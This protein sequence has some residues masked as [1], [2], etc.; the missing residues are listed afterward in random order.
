MLLEHTCTLEFFEE[1]ACRD[2]YFRF[3]GSPWILILVFTITAIT[4]LLLLLLGSN[5][6]IWQETI[7]TILQNNFNN[8]RVFVVLV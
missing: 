2:G 5:L 8:L 7:Q 4:F 1:E 6:L 3:S